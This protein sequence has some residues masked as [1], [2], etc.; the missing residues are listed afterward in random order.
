MAAADHPDPGGEREESPVAQNKGTEEEV[1][2]S[3]H[4]KELKE[5]R[6]RIQGLKKSVPKGDKRRKKEVAAEVAQLEQE[7][8]ERQERELTTLTMQLTLTAVS[9]T[10]AEV[11]DVLP[12]QL[13]GEGLEGG[14]KSR[15]QRRKEKKAQ[16]E[17]ERE[18]RIAD[19]EVEA[20][21]NNPRLRERERLITIL[22][23][24][25]LA[26]RDIPPDGHCLYAALSDQLSLKLKA[27]AEVPELRAQCA[28]Y[29]RSHSSEFLPYMTDPNTGDPYTADRFA[30]YCTEIE[31]TAAW[32]GLLEIRALSHVYQVP[33]I[34]YQADSPLLCIGEE[35]PTDSAL[36]ISYHRHEYSLGEH[37]N[38]V[39]PNTS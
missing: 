14:K 33:I 29:I 12:Q 35:H 8:Q 17:R 26:I 3:R 2:L 24:L 21:S 15:A 27:K 28:D 31:T 1:L 18:Q 36:C 4:R 5:L 37:Y 22:Q 30:Q 11:Q 13:E 38:S 39:V 16:R 10:P 19:G 7:L 25:G 20:A 6:A 34:V 23:P 32:G 9:K